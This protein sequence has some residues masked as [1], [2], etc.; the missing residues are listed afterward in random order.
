M[1]KKLLK[2]IIGPGN[3]Y[4]LKSIYKKSEPKEVIQKR[5]DFYSQLVTAGDIYFDVGAN[6][7]NRVSVM[8]S[9]GCKIIAIEPQKNCYRF[10]E[11]TY[12]SNINLVKKAVGEKEQLKQFYISD[13]HTI[14]TFSKEWIDAVKAS[15]RFKDQQWN[16]T[17]T[18]EMTTLDSLIKQ[19]GKPFFIKIDVEGYELEVLKGLSTPINCISI[20]YTVPEQTDRSIQCIEYL[21]SVY[22]E[23]KIECNY[24]VSESMEWANKSWLPATEM[25]ELIRKE[26]FIRTEFGDIYIR[27]KK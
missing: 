20:E 27:L 17:E 12:G 10:L 7:G 23:Q 24:S 1:I 4:Y 5:I 25:I 18:V 16:K 8:L 13:S 6:Y 21:Q 15:G 11:R 2:Q 19:Y 9:L 22:K 26:E 14:S 3:L